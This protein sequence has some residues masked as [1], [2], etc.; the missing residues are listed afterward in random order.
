MRRENSRLNTSKSF[1]I[2]SLLSS[3]RKLSKLLVVREGVSYISSNQIACVALYYRGDL[4][5]FL[6]TLSPSAP[7]CD[8]HESAGH[9]FREKW[10]SQDGIRWTIR[11]QLHVGSTGIPRVS[12]RPGI[13]LIVLLYTVAE[14]FVHFSRGHRHKQAPFRPNPVVSLFQIW[15]NAILMSGEITA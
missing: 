14:F 12:I 9:C 5:Q 4:Y 3:S 1:S 11:T 2:P 8:Y 6:F 10:Y 13:S 15:P 7:I